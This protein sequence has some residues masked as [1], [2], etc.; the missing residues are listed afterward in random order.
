MLALRLH[1]RQV[2]VADEALAGTDVMRQMVTI[3][4]F[5]RGGLT[6]GKSQ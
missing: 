3:G 1:F 5:S 6:R 4:P 2:I